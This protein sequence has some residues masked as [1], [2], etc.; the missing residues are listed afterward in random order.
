VVDDEEEAPEELPASR[1]TRWPGIDV[2]GVDENAQGLV[3]PV[4]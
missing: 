4:P 1:T 3:S 2:D